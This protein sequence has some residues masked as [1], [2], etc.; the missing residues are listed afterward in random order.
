M[1]LRTL[2]PKQ[3]LEEVDARR[4]DG[5]LD[6]ARD[7]AAQI[8]EQAPEFGPALHML[9]LVEFERGETVAGE[10]LMRKAIRLLPDSAE[11]RANLGRMLTRAGRYREASMRSRAPSHRTRQCLHR[12]LLATTLLS[13][14]RREMDAGRLAEALAG[15]SRAE[16]LDP[17]FA[18]AHTGKG[19]V[20]YMLGDWPGAFREYEWRW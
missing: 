4:R 15:F 18:K 10:A 9:G 7:M 6:S 12:R 2:T 19:F 5:R 17:Y 1:A 16:Q 8:V 13:W 3:A 14:A 11:A 20:L